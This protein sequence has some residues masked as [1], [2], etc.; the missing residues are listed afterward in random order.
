M[1]NLCIFG[2]MKTKAALAGL[3]EAL[4]KRANRHVA[5]AGPSYEVDKLERD[6]VTV[7]KIDDFPIFDNFGIDAFQHGSQTIFVSLS[8]PG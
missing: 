5:P 2:V 4:L 6:I 1:A 3:T 8:R 7:D